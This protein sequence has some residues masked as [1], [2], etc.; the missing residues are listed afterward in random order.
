[1]D[2]FKTGTFNTEKYGKS[3]HGKEADYEPIT[4]GDNVTDAMSKAKML[5]IHVGEYPMTIKVGDTLLQTTDRRLVMTNCHWSKNNGIQDLGRSIK[6]YV[7]IQNCQYAEMLDGL[8]EHYP[9]MGVLMCG[10]VGQTMVIQLE[11]T[12][13]EV[14]GLESEHHESTFFV[15]EDRVL[16]TN[17]YGS[18]NTR[19][20]CQNTFNMAVSEKRYKV[21]T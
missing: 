11:M 8:S 18:V 2:Y 3:W 6:R 21:I 7:P 19:I 15:A 13:F 9:V 5:D 4:N 12:P 16:G 17:Y 14:A 1:M 20:V 10:K